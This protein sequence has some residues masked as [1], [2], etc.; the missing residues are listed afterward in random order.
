[1][2]IQEFRRRQEENNKDKPVKMNFHKYPVI[3]NVNQKNK[4]N[5]KHKKH[6]TNKIV[7]STDV[8]NKKTLTVDDVL[9]SK[10]EKLKNNGKNVFIKMNNEN[11]DDDGERI[12]N[13][14][15]KKILIKWLE[16]EAK[17]I[18]KSDY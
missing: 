15:N 16:Q 13:K 2:N 9:F 1:M 12:P 8:N 18:N 11:F 10:F 17:E 7:D 4:K 5:K 14:K 6:K 3:F